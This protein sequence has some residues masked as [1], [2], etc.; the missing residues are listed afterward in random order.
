MTF[1]KHGR[2]DFIAFINLINDIFPGPKEMS[3]SF[4][5]LIAVF[6]VHFP[7]IRIWDAFSNIRNLKMVIFPLT[8]SGEYLNS[9]RFL[10]WWKYRY[11]LFLSRKKY[12][13]VF[14]NSWHAPSRTSS[15]SSLPY[16]SKWQ[17][18]SSS[19]YSENLGLILE[20]S[21]FLLSSLPSKYNPNLSTSHHLLSPYFCFCTFSDVK[22]VANAL[23]Q[24]YAQKSPVFLLLLEKILKS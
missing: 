24:S 13:V 15:S 8:W 22:P 20:A 3:C 7:A 18:H 12:L 16:L 1:N 17:L 11:D 14:L 6:Q 4:A 5:C 19:F 10:L 23:C 2:N 21:L 9:I